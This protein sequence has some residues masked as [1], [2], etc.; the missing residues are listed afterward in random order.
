[1]NCRSPHIVAIVIILVAWLTGCNVT[2]QY[3]QNVDDVG[4]QIVTEWQQLPE[5]AAAEYE[6]THGLDLGQQI[7]LRATVRAASASDAT[8]EKLTE[9]AQK[10]YWQS[11]VRSISIWFSVYSSDNPRG[12]DPKNPV[13]PIHDERVD[14]NFSDQS[15]VAELEKKYGPRPTGK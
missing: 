6:Y 5:V 9:V 10:H 8:F 13:Q 4:K 1:M 12:V 3:Q 11:G 15:Q 14:I 7:Q 2:D